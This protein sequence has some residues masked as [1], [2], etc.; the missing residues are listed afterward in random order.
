MPAI[1]VA[2]MVI[3]ELRRQIVARRAELR[4]LVEL[5]YG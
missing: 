5:D 3:A 1:E 4:A 2:D